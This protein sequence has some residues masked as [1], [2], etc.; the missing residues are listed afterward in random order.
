CRHVNRSSRDRT[1][2]ARFG[3]LAGL[4]KAFLSGMIPL[5]IALTIFSGCGSAAAQAPP[6]APAFDGAAAIAALSNTVPNFA[7]VTPGL[8]RGGQPTVVGLNKLKG[9][10]VKTILDLRNEDSIIGR[11]SRAAR[12]AGLRFENIPL[13]VFNQPSDDSIQRFLSVVNDPNN[14]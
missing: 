10:G 8:F 7:V 12:A 1:G 9:Y 6:Q 14:Q 5:S 4:M 2:L 13:D 11:E 3:I